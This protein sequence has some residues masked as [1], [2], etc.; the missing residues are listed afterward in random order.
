MN[1]PEQN[2]A[3][4][5]AGTAPAFD[6]SPRNFEEA[7]RMA[8]ILADSDFVPKDY[9]GKPGNCL[10]AMQWG[11][12]VGLK[13]LQAMQNIAVINGRPALWGDAVIALVRG[14]PLCEWIIETEDANSSTCRVKRRGEP[15]QSRTFTDED[16]KAAGLLGK[17]GPWTQYR[18]RMRQM[19]ARA[20][21]LRDVFPDVL[22][23]LPVAEEVMDAPPAERYMGP[24]DEVRPPAA[25]TLP[26]YA[27]EAFEKNLPAWTKLVADGKKTAP[28]LLAMLST[29]A[30]FS[31]QQ[32]AH[33][34]SLK[35][36]EAPAAPPPPAEREPGADDD[37]TASYDAAEEG[38]K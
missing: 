20:F 3:L 4:A 26:P 15:E 2:R 14:S 8:E 17:Q 36:A 5:V 18:R 13:A 7:W 25:P 9:K 33:I 34:L 37:W 24:V 35:K 29:K 38:A 32:K 16:A 19:R 22:R 28:E 1:A 11:A 30:A 6:L 31:E 12:E 21:A 27:A 23:G 10:V